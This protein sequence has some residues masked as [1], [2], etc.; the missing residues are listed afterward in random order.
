MPVAYHSRASSIVPSGTKIHRPNGQRLPTRSS[1]LSLS[2]A[3]LSSA[4]VFGPTEQLDF[5]AEL[6][7]LI[8]TG[9]DLGRPIPVDEAEQHVFGMVLLNDWSG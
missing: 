7:A 3:S 1:S 2:P 5:E 6:G 4:P 8:G 9:N